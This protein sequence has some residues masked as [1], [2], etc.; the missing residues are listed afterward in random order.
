MT[1]SAAVLSLRCPFALVSDPYMDLNG[2]LADI[3]LINALVK[4]FVKSKIE[5]RVNNMRWS[6]CE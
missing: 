5:A 4:Q 2:Y 6:R 3:F 1:H